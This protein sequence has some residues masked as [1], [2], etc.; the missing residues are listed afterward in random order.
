MAKGEYTSL[1]TELPHFILIIIV[2]FLGIFAFIPL[3]LSYLLPPSKKINIL[4]IFTHYWREIFVSW[5]GINT[6]FF[7][8]LILSFSY[9]IGYVIT[10]L[11]DIIG[12]K[13]IWCFAKLYDKYILMRFKDYK[14]LKKYFDRIK[15]AREFMKREFSIGTPEY[16]KFQFELYQPFNE[17]YRIYYNWEFI[18]A[19]SC[20]YISFLVVIF[21]FIFTTYYLLDKIGWVNIS[22]NIQFSCRSVVFIYG[23]LIISFISLLYG[24]LFYGSARH[25][26]QVEAYKEIMK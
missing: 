11:Y 12:G 8:I 14:E 20:E 19:V 13:I 24:S 16:A 22:D 7:L 4:L 6:I 23:L 5:S 1:I 21:F 2:G 17:N 9:F 15:K 26:A 10:G 25:I 18:K 3:L